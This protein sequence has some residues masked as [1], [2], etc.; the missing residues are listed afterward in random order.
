MINSFW[1]NMKSATQHF[2]FSFGPR[3]IYAAIAL[4]IGLICI[5]IVR[6]LILRLMR[7][8]NAD[9][10]IQGFIKSITTAMLWAILIFIVGIILGVKASAFFTMFGAAG[11]AIGLALQGS[12][13]NFAG[14]LLILIF[15]PFKVGDEVII[16]GVQGYV[17]DINI[18]YTSVNNWRGE[19]FTMPNGKVSNNMVRNNSADKYRRVQIELHF[20]HDVDIDELRKII[21]STMK[22]HPKTIAKKPYQFWVSSFEDYYIK[23]SAR[24]WCKTD[25]YWEV[26]WDQEEA[27]KKALAEKGISLAIPKQA[28]HQPDLQQTIDKN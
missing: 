23:T 7:K 15:K 22:K 19:V 2:I 4:V 9:L 26:Y 8:A 16:D 13:S 12:L 21:I 27:I 10:S 5:K 1:E 3:L 20:N 17:E 28:I 14:G 11:I 24:C 25:I 6:N 18:L